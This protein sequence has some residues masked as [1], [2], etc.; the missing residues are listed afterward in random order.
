VPRS[1]GGQPPAWF[2]DKNDSQSIFASRAS[3][4]IIIIAFFLVSTNAASIS[5]ALFFNN[6]C[7]SVFD[8]YDPAQRNPEEDGVFGI[9]TSGNRW[10][11]FTPKLFRT[12]RAA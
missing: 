4:F 1:T 5:Q 7:R 11:P 8:Q 10:A 9:A 3:F 12:K 2:W 6:S